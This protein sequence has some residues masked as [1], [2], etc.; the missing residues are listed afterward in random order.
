M[1]IERTETITREVLYRLIDEL[2]DFTLPTVEHYLTTLRDDSL[3]QSL[4]NAPLEDEE[5]SEGEQAMLARAEE[6]RAWRG[7]I[8]HQRGTGTRARRVSR[9]LSIW[10]W[11]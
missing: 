2:P 7:S 9:S 6:K 4:A 8:R 3:I 1:T 5:L 10:R 11:Y